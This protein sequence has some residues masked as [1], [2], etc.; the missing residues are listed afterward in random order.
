M[1]EKNRDTSNPQNET[2]YG[3]ASPL[4]RL[5]AAIIDVTLLLPLVQLFQAPLRRSILESF[6]FY[7]GQA[8]VVLRFL[9]IFAFI[10][11]F[12]LY[13]SILN[14]WKGQTIGKMFFRLQVVSYQGKLTFF[15]SLNR[16]FFLVLGIAA[17]GIPLLALFTHPLRRAAHDRFSDTL[18]LGLKRTAGYPSMREIFRARILM[19]LSSVFV[20]FL[21]SLFFIQSE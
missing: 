3:I 10:A 14:S 20:L 8:V 2:S 21:I 16:S 1:E 5:A 7:D 12:V 4:D 17:F 15:Q 9:N 11:V 19:G 6:L 18:V 13:H